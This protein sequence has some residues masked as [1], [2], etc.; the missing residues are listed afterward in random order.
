MSWQMQARMLITRR[1]VRGELWVWPARRRVWVASSK[2]R[3]QLK[4]ADQ[5]KVVVSQCERLEQKQR[6]LRDSSAQLE[7]SP[8]R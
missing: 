6:M 4:N 7:P 8:P 1:P 3:R 2:P 5:C